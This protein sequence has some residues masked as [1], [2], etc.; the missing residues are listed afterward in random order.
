[1]RSN[2]TH[3]HPQ[4]RCLPY[5]RQQVS[6][7]HT[8]LTCIQPIQPVLYCMYYS[9][10]SINQRTDHTRV[11]L[12]TIPATVYLPGYLLSHRRRRLHWNGCGASRGKVGT[13]GSKGH[14]WYGMVW[15]G[16]GL[17][18]HTD[19]SMY[20]WYAPPSLRVCLYVCWRSNGR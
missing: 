19:D 2:K 9:R 5:D 10:A 17:D 7:P 1:M 20:A 14:V 13:V 3:K 12:P 16:G 6:Q 4:N 8:S 15:Y 11:F 18:G